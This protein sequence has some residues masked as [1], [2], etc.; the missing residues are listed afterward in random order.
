MIR[1]YKNMQGSRIHALDGDIGKLKDIYFD[2][3]NWNVRY[4]VVEL[5]SSGKE[6]LVSPKVVASFDGE[7]LKI[8]LTKK[9]I[10]EFP[11]S[12]DA[13]PVSMQQQY[14]AR[15]LFDSASNFSG[16]FAGTPLITHIKTNNEDRNVYD[17]HLLS[18]KKISDY[19]LVTHDVGVGDIQDILIDDAFWLIRFL[20]VEIIDNGETRS[21]VLSPQLIEEIEWPVLLVSVALDYDELMRK[22][23]FN[24]QKHLDISYEALVNELLNQK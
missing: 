24:R 17:P 22:P 6:M 7:E 11:D 14:K 1:N 12:E 15:Y 19:Q 16:Q 20:V 18:C 2:D 4:F 13:L 8:E 10:N 9:E 5:G 21:I 3:H 23:V